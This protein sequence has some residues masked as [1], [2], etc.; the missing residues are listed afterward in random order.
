MS[1]SNQLSPGVVIQERDLSTVTTPSAFNV[2]V[3]AAPFNRG[4]VE[5]ITNISSERQL[6]DIFGEPDDQNY[7]YW[8]TASQFLAY[9]GTLKTI[10]IA[11]DTLRNAVSDAQTAELIKNLQAYETTFEGRGGTTWN[12]AARTPGA[13]G[14]SIGIFVTDAGPDQIAVLPAPGTGNEHEFV[15]DE[16]V[17]TAS[18]AAGRVYKYALKLT[19]TSIVSNFTAGSTATITIGG[20]GQTVDVLAWDASNKVLEIGLQSGGVTGIIA[21][22]S[23]TIAQGGASGTIA[24][25]ERL[26]YV[27]LD[28]SSIAFKGT[29]SIQDTNSTAVV[30]TSVRTEYSEREYLPGVKW[31]NVA[32]RPG[33]SLYANGIGGSDDELHIL[34][35][36][37]DGKITGTPGAVLERYIAVSKAS[38]AKTSVG[39]VNYYKEVIKQKS[40]YVY[41]GKH[42]VAAHPGTNGDAAAGN[43][44]QAAANRRFNR[45]RNAAGSQDYP[46]GSTTVGSRNNATFYYRLAGGVDYTVAGGII[47]LSNTDIAASYDLVADPESQTI[48][49]ILSGPAGS[50]NE[51]ALAK[52]STLMN[53]VEERRDCMAFFSPKRGDVI[54]ISDS[55]TITDNI[56]NYFDLLPSSSY[57][58]FDSGYKYIYDKYNDVY[59]YVPTNGDVAGLCVQTTEVS[60][61]WYSPA[62]FARGVLRNAI[63]LAY[64]PN[65]IQRDTLYANRVNPVVSFPGQGIVLFGDKTAQSFASAFDRINVRRLFLVIERVVG[66]AAKTQLFEQNDEA[67]R[68]LFLNIVEPYLRDVQGRRG[69]TDFLVKCDSENNPPQAVDRGEFYAEIYVKPTRTINYITLTFVATRTGVAFEE[70]AS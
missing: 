21:D 8:Y 24:S 13:L 23:D 40:N 6:V 16:A 69:V 67:Q 65:K 15:A 44:G 35:V 42:E 48:D 68:N 1:A 46:A 29:D 20:S 19:L 11:S 52:V 66:T 26:L 51:I 43:W 25:T 7:E 41:W 61:P 31:I 57:A 32:P 36:D 18:G 4:P 53:L 70:V 10:R 47:S 5:E 28:A 34:V 49:F 54:G 14:D 30:I 33:T 27:G 63:K 37:I 56:V 39:E 22:S 2:G 3:M 9:G 64:T 50:T 58:V 55:S 62:G 59:R 12:W 38:D 17:T 45:L 60:E